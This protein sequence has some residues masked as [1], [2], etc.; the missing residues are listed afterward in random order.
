MFSG[1]YM[2]QVETMSRCNKYLDKLRFE[3]WDVWQMQYQ[4]YHPEGFHAWFWKT[5]H[6]DI[7]LVTHNEDVQKAIVSFNAKKPPG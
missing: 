4:W 7:E 1:D 3:G 6:E 5:G 2:Y